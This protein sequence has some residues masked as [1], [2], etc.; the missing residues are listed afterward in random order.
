MHSDL[1]EKLLRAIETKGAACSNSRPQPLSKTFGG[2]EGGG[3][4]VGRSA[5]GVPNGG[6]GQWEPQ[7]TYLKMLSMTR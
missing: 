3:R 2:L 6:G 4:W 5:A 7:H 1:W